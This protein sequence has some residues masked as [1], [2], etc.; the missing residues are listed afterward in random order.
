[1]GNFERQ[2][3]LLHDLLQHFA[4][5]ALHNGLCCAYAAHLLHPAPQQLLRPVRAIR[6]GAI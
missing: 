1:M 4:L 2:R 3:S 6:P 5:A